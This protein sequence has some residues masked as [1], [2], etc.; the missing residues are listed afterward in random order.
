MNVEERLRKLEAEM[1][2]IKY[3]NK[4][5]QSV[6]SMKSVP[7]WAEKALQAAEE[8]GAFESPVGNGLDYYRILDLL[9]KKGVL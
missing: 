3:Q 9:L 7:V 1:I 4:A 5:L 2:K 8:S 6:V